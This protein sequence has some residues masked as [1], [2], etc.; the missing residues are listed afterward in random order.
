MTQSSPPNTLAIDTSTDACSVA[1]RI[2]GVESRRCELIP[3]QHSQRL[4]SMLAELLPGGDLHAS[5]VELLAYCHGPG[6]FTGLRIAASAAQG[7]AYSNRLPVAGISSLA[8]LALGAARSAGLADGTLLLPMLDARINEVYHGLYRYRDGRVHSLREDRVCAPAD[9]SPGWESAV[10]PAVA[11]GSG[12]RYRDELP[13]S[14]RDNLFDELPELW[15][16]ARELLDLAAD[17]LAAGQAVS[18][19]DVQPVYIR[20]EI[21]WKKL[22]DQGRRS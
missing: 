12:L 22:A 20:D 1:L 13:G 10:Q 2:D 9:L 16:D 11:V 21:G 19:M 4:F 17:C 8:C 15:P 7:L 6:S 5:G 14:V 3:R 18:A